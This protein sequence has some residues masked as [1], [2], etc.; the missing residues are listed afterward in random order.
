MFKFGK[1]LA[2]SALTASVISLSALAAGSNIPE[3][4]KFVPKDSLM[5]LDIKTTQTA[6]EVIKKNKSLSKIDLFKEMA[7]LDAKN[8]FIGTLFNTDHVMNFGDNLVVS[9]LDFNIET[10][11]VPGLL[12]VE[13]MKNSDAIQKFKTK[14]TEVGKKSKDHK[15]QDSKFKDAEVITFTSSKGEKND[16]FYFAIVNNYIITSNRQE[17]LMKSLNSFYTQDLS[18]M[19]SNSML[20]LLRYNLEETILPVKKTSGRLSLLKSAM[21]TPP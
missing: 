9:L 7:K 5:S 2:V 21:P 10:E 11:S 16:D 8:S 18:V 3:S 15:R 14:L 12:I 13:E 17:G 4:Y 20:P 19:S 6:W 1:T